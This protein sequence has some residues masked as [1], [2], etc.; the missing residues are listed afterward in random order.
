M[1]TKDARGYFCD[2]IPSTVTH[3]TNPTTPNNGIRFIALAQHLY[4]YI[5]LYIANMTRIRHL[6]KEEK[7][8]KSVQHTKGS[9]K[10]VFYNIY[11]TELSDVCVVVYQTAVCEKKK[12]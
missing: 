4:I 7:W 12:L 10:P 6:Y 11:E 5:I 2:Y 1:Y 9:R 8:L 3:V